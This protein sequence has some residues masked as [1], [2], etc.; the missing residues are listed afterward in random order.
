M[1]D[2]TARQRHVYFG[3]R[4]QRRQRSVPPTQQQRTQRL[5]IGAGV[6]DA[7]HHRHAAI[8]L[9]ELGRLAAVIS[10]IDR[11][12]H[13]RRLQAVDGQ[14]FGLEFHVQFHLARRN[15]QADV[16]AGG[17]APQDVDDLRTD[18][19]VGVEIG[20]DHADRKRRGLA[21]QRLAD[22]LGQHRIDFHELVRVVVE[23][24]A[25]RGID[26]ARAAPLLGVDLHLELALVGRIRILSVLGAADLLGDALDA[27]NRNQS[28][29][30]LRA[31]AGGFGQRDSGTQ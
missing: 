29:G 15:R 10:R 24:I 19:V 11:L 14:L 22:A 31:D 16:A 13:I 6:R 27:R 7:H 20:A 1:I 5:R 18:E 17:Q 3:D 12:Q 25:D 9:V 26:L 8:R 21:G 23:H 30:N 2:Q 4:G 28:L